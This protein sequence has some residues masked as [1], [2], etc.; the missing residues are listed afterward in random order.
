MVELLRWQ[1]SCRLE[2]LSGQDESVQREK[3]DK[4]ERRSRK[5]QVVSK[6]CILDVLQE[7]QG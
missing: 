5:D 7:A 3:Q 1:S 4:V 2:L 6:S